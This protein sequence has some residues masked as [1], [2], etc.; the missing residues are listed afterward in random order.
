MIVLPIIK[1]LTPQIKQNKIYTRNII[2]NI[3]FTGYSQ[4]KKIDAMLKKFKH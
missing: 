4:N 1:N 2:I 3:N